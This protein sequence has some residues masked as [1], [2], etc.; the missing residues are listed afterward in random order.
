VVVPRLDHLA[1]GPELINE[2][3]SLDVGELQVP[4]DALEAPLGHEGAE[5]VGAWVLLLL[6][7]DGIVA[8]KLIN[9]HPEHVDIRRQMPRKRRS[10]PKG[11]GVVPVLTTPAFVSG[12]RM[13][14]NHIIGKK[15]MKSWR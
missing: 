8:P 15:C 7:G 2:G 1:N 4:I 14:E 12:N 3:R 6:S 5:I 13:A 10:L 9:V 11:T